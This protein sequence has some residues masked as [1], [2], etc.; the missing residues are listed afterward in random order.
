MNDRTHHQRL[1]EELRKL[2]RRA[3]DA[4][5]DLRDGDYVNAETQ[6]LMIR[7]RLDGLIEELAKMPSQEQAT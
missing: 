1:A 4:T 2:Y 6:L 5:I 3:M 7:Q